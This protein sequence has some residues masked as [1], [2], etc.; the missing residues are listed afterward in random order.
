LSDPNAGVI[1]IL[2]KTLLWVWLLSIVGFVTAVLVALLGVA[3]WVGI[4]TNRVD[5]VPLAALIAYPL[6]IVL[7]LFPSYYLHKYSRRIRVFVAQGHTVQLEA[8]LDAQRAFWRFIGVIVLL[9]VGCTAAAVVVGM[10]IGVM[11][12]L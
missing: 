6:L 3:S 8:A 10:V 9:V 2:R 1:Q 11:A 5:A 4:S 12:A 7:Y